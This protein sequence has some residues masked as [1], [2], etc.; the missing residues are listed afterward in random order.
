MSSLPKTELTVDW[1]SRKAAKYAVDNWHYSG[2]MPSAGRIYIGIWE[3]GDFVGVIIF[4]QG[5]TPN[6]RK[7][8]RLE[9]TEICE[10]TRVACKQHGNQITA[11]IKRAIRLLKTHCPGL[12]LIVSYA[13]GD[14]D[15]IGIIY[16]AGNWIYT[17]AHP[18]ER[19]MLINNR[20]E[21]RRT[22]NSRYGTS[23]IEWIKTNIDLDAK[24]VRGDV[25]HKYLY[26]LDKAMRRQIEKLRQPYPKRTPGGGASEPTEAGGSIPTRPLQTVKVI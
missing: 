6:I 20:L 16:Q 22:V 15:H 9:S 23:S 19:G 14:Y 21:H 26:P 4:S 18:S 24:I 13:D 17:G 1:C 3:G 11:M 2:R 10:L 25:K 7:P 8:Y 12:R 5:A